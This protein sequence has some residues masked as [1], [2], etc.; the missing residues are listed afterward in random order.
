M[1][2]MGHRS[3]DHRYGAQRLDSRRDVFEIRL[4]L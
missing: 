2:G 4:C 1:T 3:D